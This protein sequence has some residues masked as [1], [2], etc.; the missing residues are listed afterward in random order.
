MDQRQSIPK[1]VACKV[2]EPKPN[3]I[4]IHKSKNSSAPKS[5][6]I[7]SHSLKSVSAKTISLDKFK[8]VLAISVQL[9]TL[10]L[11]RLR[12]LVEH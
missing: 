1:P 9:Y 4:W 5:K 8:T 6:S 3:L 11:L 2:R 10:F 12:K 7:F